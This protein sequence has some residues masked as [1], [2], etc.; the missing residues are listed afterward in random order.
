MARLSVSKY[1][2]FRTCPRLYYFSYV[3][4][5]E[6]VRQEGARRYGDLFHKALEAWW[7]EM[8]WGTT[9][10]PWIDTDGAL[11]KMLAAIAADARHIETDPYEVA[12]AEAMAIVYH[13]RWRELSYTM[14]RSDVERWFEV[15]LRDPDGML[16]P[17]WIINGKKDG[18]ATFDGTPRLVEHKTTTQE[19]DAGSLYFRKLAT[20]LQVSAYLDTAAQY[21]GHP[22][23]GALYD[24]ARKPDIAP[25][26]ATPEELREYTKGKRCKLCS[27]PKEEKGSGIVC[28]KPTKK[29]DHKIVPARWVENGDGS[30]MPD[31]ATK[32]PACDGSGMEEQ[33]RLYAKHRAEDEPVHEYKQRVLD[34][35]TRSPDTYFF[36]SIVRRD[37]HELMEA[38]ADLVAMACEVDAAFARMRVA[39]PN[40][41]R[42][43]W[44]RNHNACHSQYGRSCDFLEVCTTGVDPLQTPLYRI[45]PRPTKGASK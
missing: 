12:R 43:A 24:V 30:S 42:H 28:E 6:R 26:R 35:L 1:D 13:E 21:L 32:C 16:V 38:R 29:G 44:P 8:G 18:I 31:G 23:D 15:P 20:N 41:E 45:K 4:F 10:P 34:E 9:P 19:I 7:P 27:E 33:P 14:N 11:Q 3:L 2:T 36:Q 37:E 25:G 40:R 5:I 39:M 22:L 17:N